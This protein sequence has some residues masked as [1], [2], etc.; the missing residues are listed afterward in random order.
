MPNVNDWW[1]LTNPQFHL[2]ISIVALIV[3]AFVVA[4]FLVVV[5]IANKLEGTHHEDPRQLRLFAGHGGTYS[6]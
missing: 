3:L 4:I 1:I 6:P 5:G 2:A